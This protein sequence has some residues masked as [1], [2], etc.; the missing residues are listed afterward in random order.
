M[1]WFSSTA[2]WSAFAVSP[3]RLSLS[4]SW[5]VMAA[6]WVTLLSLAMEA[7]VCLP[8]VKES[9]SSLRSL[10]LR[11]NFLPVSPTEI[12]LVCSSSLT[13][14]YGWTTK[15]RSVRWGWSAVAMPWDFRILANASLSPW[16]PYLCDCLLCSFLS[17]LCTFQRFLHDVL[18]DTINN[19]GRTSQHHLL[20][21]LATCSSF[22]RSSS[23]V[24][25]L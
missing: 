10:I 18:F 16:Q 24:T 9:T 1:I 21:A 22:F 2:G 23:S 7:Q 4:L 14:S 20:S 6:L 3:S 11:L 19:P 15:C 13:L 8:A 17:L 12:N 25:M 5:S